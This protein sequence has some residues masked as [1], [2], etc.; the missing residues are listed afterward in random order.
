MAVDRGDTPIQGILRPMTHD[1]RLA[2]L[3]LASSSVAPTGCASVLVDGQAGYVSSTRLDDTHRGLAAQLSSGLALGDE[4]AEHFGPGMALRTKFTG[5]VRQF[6]LAPHVYYVSDAGTTPYAR[7]GA[8]LLQF[9]R[10]EGESAFG[11]FSPYGE[12]GVFVTPFVFSAFAEYD[13]RFTHQPNEG[14]FGIMVG[15]GLAASTS[16]L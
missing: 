6:A 11:M 12:A 9:E 15:W 13:L 1:R 16:A 2:L 10:I 14:F 3:L 8:N 7:A 5:E 4:T